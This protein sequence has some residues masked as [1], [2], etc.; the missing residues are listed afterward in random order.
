MLDTKHF[1]VY[2]NL[3]KKKVLLEWVQM[4]DVV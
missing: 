1:G 4:G 3:E 2:L